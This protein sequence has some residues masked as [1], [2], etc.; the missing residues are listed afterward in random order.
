MQNR[1]KYLTSFGN[2]NYGATASGFRN[3]SVTFYYCATRR[4]NCLKP[5]LNY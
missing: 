1:R 2:I 4:V 3:R 5:W